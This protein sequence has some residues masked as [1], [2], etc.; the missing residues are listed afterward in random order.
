LAHR[1]KLDRGLTPRIV[2]AIAAGSG[3]SLLLSLLGANS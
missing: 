3:L 1:L 2:V